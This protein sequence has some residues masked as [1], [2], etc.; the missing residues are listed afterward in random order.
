MLKFDNSALFQR[1]KSEIKTST[2]DWQTIKHT[3]LQTTLIF[4]HSK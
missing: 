4:S 3:K 1:T 2:L